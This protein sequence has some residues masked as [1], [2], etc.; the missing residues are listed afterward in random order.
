LL[1]LSRA[2]CRQ[3]AQ[4]GA[5]LAHVLAEPADGRAQTRILQVAKDLVPVPEGVDVADLP[6]QDAG[7]QLALVPVGCDRLDDLIEVEVGEEAWPAVSSPG[8]PSV[9]TGDSRLV[10]SGSASTPAAYELG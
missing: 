8:R 5:D 10:K 9:R 1:L 3:L 6:V 7:D 4:M 2:H